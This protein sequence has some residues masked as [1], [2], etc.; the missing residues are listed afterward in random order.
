MD[1][2]LSKILPGE[3]A[4]VFDM[5]LDPDSLRRWMAPGDL[6]VARAEVNPVVGGAFRIDMQ[7]PD[8]GVL[9]HTGHYLEIQR[10]NRLVFTWISSATGQ[11]ETQVTLD[12][13]THARGC[14][15]ELRHESLPG[16]LAVEQHTDGWTG[17]LAKLEAQRPA[18]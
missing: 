6:Q 14:R 4:E 11:A 9:V 12:F 16:Q 5:W 7:T 8:G 17:I 1:L 13:Y 10:P 2:T 15:L 18:A 3:P